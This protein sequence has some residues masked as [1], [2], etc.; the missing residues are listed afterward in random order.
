[1]TRITVGDS[2]RQTSIV[3]TVGGSYSVVVTDANGCV[4]GPVIYI[5]SITSGVEEISINN[6]NIYPNPSRDVFNITFKIEEK[7]NL[8]VRILNVIGEKVISDNLQQFVGEYTKEIDLTNK[9]KGIYFL[10]I[11]T[12]NGVTNKKIILQ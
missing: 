12:D 2:Q 5:F 7:Q 11:E 6:L 3:P 4:S 8:K 10:E 1:M 9:A